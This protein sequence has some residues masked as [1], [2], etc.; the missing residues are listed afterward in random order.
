MSKKSS[1]FAAG[2]IG[3]TDKN[4]KLPVGKT[5]KID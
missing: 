5:D 3:K 4:T 1:N 2:I